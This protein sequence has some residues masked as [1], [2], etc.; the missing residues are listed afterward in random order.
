MSF[1]RYDALLRSKFSDAIQVEQQF[2][3]DCKLTH[4]EHRARVDINIQIARILPIFP[5]FSY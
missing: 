4:S 1:L 5:F 3:V 2:P